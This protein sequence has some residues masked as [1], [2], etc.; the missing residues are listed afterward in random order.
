MKKSTFREIHA[1]KKEDHK[2]EQ[3]KKETKKGGK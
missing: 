1:E 3:P 2:K